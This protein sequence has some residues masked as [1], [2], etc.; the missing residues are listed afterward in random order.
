MHVAKASLGGFGGQYVVRHVDWG[1]PAAVL[2]SACQALR[3]GGA[4]VTLDFDTDLTFQ[5]ALPSRRMSSSVIW[6]LMSARGSRSVGSSA[7]AGASASASAAA[8][9][10]LPLAPWPP[11]AAAGAPRIRRVGTTCVRVMCCTLS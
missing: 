1:V 2:Y 8:A 5:L 3:D 4:G 10:R 6:L 11:A 7:A 9:A